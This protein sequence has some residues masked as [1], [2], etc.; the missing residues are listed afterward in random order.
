MRLKVL[1]CSGGIGKGLRTS[2]YMVDDDILMDAGTGVGDLSIEEMKGLKH[3]F[4]THSHLDHV[5]SIPLLIDTLFE[6]LTEPLNIY[7]SRETI[8]A[9]KAHVFNW[10]L[11]PDFS[12]LPNKNS[13]VMKYHILRKGEAITIGD[14]TVNYMHVNH[15]VPGVA[16]H[17]QNTTSSVCYSGD[18]TTCDSLWNCINHKK[19]LSMLIVECAFP[20]EN[21][22]LA[23]LAKHYCPNTLVKDL[24]K[25]SINAQIAITHLKPGGE[26]DTKDQLIA[27]LPEHD[28]IF[29]ENGNVFDL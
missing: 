3:I 10:T 12:E 24:K 26:Q 17:I 28:L 6:S 7:G 25:L 13:A 22:E 29:L 5:C 2:S 11:W 18:T 15:A 14:R 1:G 20:N 9:L 21:E 16:Y 4:L 23:G 8:D 27:L 19:S